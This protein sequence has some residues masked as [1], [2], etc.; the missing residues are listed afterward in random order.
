MDVVVCK[1][2]HQEACDKSMC[3][4]VHVQSCKAFENAQDVHCFYCR[5]PLPVDVVEHRMSICVACMLMIRNQCPKGNDCRLFAKQMCT[6]FHGMYDTRPACPTPN[7]MKRR[8]P[9]HTYC[10]YCNEKRKLMFREHNCRFTGRCKFAN[11]CMDMHGMN[12]TRPIC[13]GCNA[14]TN[15]ADLCVHCSR[16]VS[17]R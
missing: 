15:G 17:R 6:F 3:Y 14:M 5:N 4:C 11:Q 1:C 10:W 7:C 8:H 16:T 12:D 2:P 13:G 9:E